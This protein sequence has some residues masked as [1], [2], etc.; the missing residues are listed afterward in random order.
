MLFHEPL[1]Q[2]LVHISTQVS[3]IPEPTLGIT[4]YPQG[5]RGVPDLAADADPSTG[6]LVIQDGTF[7]PYIWG[8][9]S[10]SAPLTAGMTALVQ[11]NNRYFTIGD[12]APTLYQLYTQEDDGFYVHQTTFSLSQLSYGVQGTMFIT[13][14][15]QNGEFYVT[16]GVWNP[17]AGLGQLNVYGISQTISSFGY[18]E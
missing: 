7:S 13:A 6:V 12:L 3:S 9:T 2:Q 11:G 10:L 15:G 5:Q 1:G 14:S 16:P 18:G 17:V 4:F 8:G